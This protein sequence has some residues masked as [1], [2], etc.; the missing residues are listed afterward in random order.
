MLTKLLFETAITYDQLKR[1]Y[2]GYG[3]ADLTLLGSDLDEFT[4]LVLMEQGMVNSS[5][6]R[7]YRMQNIFIGHISDNRIELS[8]E[9]LE[10]MRLFIVDLTRHDMDEEK[11]LQHLLKQYR[12]TLAA[13]QQ[14]AA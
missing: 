4:N 14:L 9:Q 11:R 3:I 12:A 10:G 7:E 5:R 2:P 1:K 6:S 8:P 13:R